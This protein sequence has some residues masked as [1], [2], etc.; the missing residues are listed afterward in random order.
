MEYLLERCGHGCPLTTSS[1]QLVMAPNGAGWSLKGPFLHADD[2][3]G[4]R[5]DD[6]Y[7]EHGN[8]IQE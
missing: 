6:I 7:D 2:H 1:R 3:I 5:I 8:L 4:Q